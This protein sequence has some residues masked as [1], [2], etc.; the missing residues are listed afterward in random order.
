M[1]TLN[2]DLTIINDLTILKWKEK[3]MYLLWRLEIW[4]SSIWELE[5][6]I[7]MEKKSRNST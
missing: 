6:N 2:N 7:K 1:K 4:E 5:G 3:E